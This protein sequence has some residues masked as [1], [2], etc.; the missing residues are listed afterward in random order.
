MAASFIAQVALTII[1]I[2]ILLLYLQ[3]FSVHSGLR[4]TIYTVIGLL[5]SNFAAGI[6]VF[7]LT[8][9]PLTKMIQPELPGKC[10]DIDKVAISQGLINLHFDIVIFVLPLPT[11]WLLQLPKR[12]KLATSAILTLGLM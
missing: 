11:I 5:A 1:K 3:L 10:L 2:S 4:Y 6:T 9:R 8:C 12:K 7:L